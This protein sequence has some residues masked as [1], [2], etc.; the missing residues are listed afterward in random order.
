MCQRH[1]VLPRIANFP[2]SNAV[3]HLRMSENSPLACCFDA[4]IAWRRFLPRHIN[5][6]NQLITYPT[7]TTHSQEPSRQYNCTMGNKTIYILEIPQVKPNAV[8]ITRPVMLLINVH[9]VYTVLVLIGGPWGEA[10]APHPKIFTGF[11]LGGGNTC[12]P[13]FLPDT[14]IWK[15]YLKRISNFFKICSKFS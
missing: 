4:L 13:K 8:Y 2:G 14:M 9:L 11:N 10:R 7:H 15:V 12:P 3:T 1:R 5:Q 6:Y